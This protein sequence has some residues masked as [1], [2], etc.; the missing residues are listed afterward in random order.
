MANA[1]VD[2]CS[3]LLLKEA[4]SRFDTIP[5]ETAGG[6]S[7]IS[8]GS[9]TSPDADQPYSAALH[10]AFRA[11][12]TQCNV[13]YLAPMTTVY[14]DDTLLS[15][16]IASGPPD[17]CRPSHESAKTM[18]EAGKVWAFAVT[19]QNAVRAVQ[20]ALSNQ[21]DPE[22]RDAW[23]QI[24]IYCLSGATLAS[25]K[26]VGF[27]TINSCNPFRSHSTGKPPA[28]EEAPSFDNGDQL[29][30]FLLSLDWPTAAAAD[31]KDKDCEPALWFLTGETRMKTLAEKLSAHCKPFLEV[32]VYKTVPRPGFEQELAAWLART[33]KRT[34]A[35]ADGEEQRTKTLWLAG[36][37]PR[38]VDLTIPTLWK[39]LADSQSAADIHDLRGTGTSAIA[40]VKWAAIGTTT[41]KRISEHLSQLHKI[42]RESPG[43]IDVGSE[44]AVAKAP[45]P[46]ALAE[47]IVSGTLREEVPQ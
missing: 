43:P 26:K 24:P 41:A 29:V 21:S 46:L 6:S 23:L 45:N 36:F 47:A 31:A 40:R 19:S 39:F 2:S 34:S 38:G 7:V 16:A 25:V 8:G 15:R 27:K 42:T 35:W 32:I 1:V 3:I 13:E 28:L 11:I 9:G 22:V 20:E 17:R 12:N 30:D 4:S 14:P 10:S 44:V 5:G 18:N 37:S 33:S